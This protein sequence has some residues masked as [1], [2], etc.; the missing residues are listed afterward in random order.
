VVVGALALDRHADLPVGTL[1]V[2][3]TAF[4]T[5]SRSLEALVDT[6]MNGNCHG[7]LLVEMGASRPTAVETQI[8]AALLLMF[9]IAQARDRSDIINT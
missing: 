4:E 1:A 6:G 9:Q 2:Q 5:G 8:A 7:D 3:R